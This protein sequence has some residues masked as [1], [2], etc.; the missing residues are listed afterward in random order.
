M[1]ANPQA[2][3]EYIRLPNGRRAH[4]C[5]TI[6]CRKPLE[7]A[8]APMPLYPVPEVGDPV[9][10]KKQVVCGP[11]Y[12]A[13]FELIYPGK[14]LPDMPDAIIEGVDPVF[15][16]FTEEEPLPDDDDYAIWELAFAQSKGSGGAE[17]VI[18]AYKR[19][20]SDPEV[21]VDGLG[22]TDLDPDRVPEVIP[23]RE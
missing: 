4:V 7:L 10:Y 13:Q 23:I 16:K 18:Q 2:S 6:T 8:R 14:E 9:P 11:C 5:A 1:V 20:L 17:T 12:R 3:Y 15:K 21:T 22:G 19:L